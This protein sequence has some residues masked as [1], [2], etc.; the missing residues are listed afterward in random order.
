MGVNG[1]GKTTSI[2]KVAHKYIKE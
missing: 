2:A 1:C